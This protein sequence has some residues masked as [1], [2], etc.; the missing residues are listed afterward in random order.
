M[1]AKTVQVDGGFSLAQFSSPETTSSIQSVALACLF[2]LL[3]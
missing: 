3:S 2:P 1:A